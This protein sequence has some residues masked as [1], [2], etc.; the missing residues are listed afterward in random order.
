MVE[1]TNRLAAGVA[2]LIAAVAAVDAVRGEHWDQ[3][4]MLAA[5]ALLLVVL[6]LVDIMRPA[7]VVV[8]A[9]VA[10]WLRDEAA[11]TDDSMSRIVARAVA[12]H[13]AGRGEG[14]S[15]P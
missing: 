3:L 9:D 7:C 11:R 8:R 6:L 13:R 10:V 15:E 12:E 1:T 5:I 4:A 2:L 14:L